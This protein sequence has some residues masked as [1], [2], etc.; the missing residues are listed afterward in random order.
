MTTRHATVKRFAVTA[1]MATA[2]TVVG[3]GLGS[4][5]AQATTIHPCPHMMFCSQIHTRAQSA[6][7][8]FDSVQGVFRVG[9]STRLDKAVDRLFGVK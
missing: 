5:T 3:L 8:F 4:G 7:N 2:V 9:E 6:D 1:V